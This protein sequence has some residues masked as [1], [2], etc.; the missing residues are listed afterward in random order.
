METVKKTADYFA[1]SVG[2]TLDALLPSYVISNIS[3]FIKNLNENPHEKEKD[4][5]NMNKEKYA[6]QGDEEER[7]G[8]WKSLITSCSWRARRWL[9][10]KKRKCWLTGY[11]G[12]CRRGMSQTRLPSRICLK[13]A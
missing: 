1:G 9:L 5:T 2:A 3:T 11:P 10:W 7:Y 8:T 13:R 12:R 4:D 6:V